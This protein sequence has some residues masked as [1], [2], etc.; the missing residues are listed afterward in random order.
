MSHHIYLPNLKS[1][2]VRDFSLYPG[3]LDFRYDFV[4]GVNLILGGNGIGKT[5]FVN[6][7]KYGLIGLY[8]KDF[9]FQRTYL[10]RKIESRVQYP[11][12]YFAN[13]MDGSYQNNENAYV[14]LS[15]QLNDTQFKVKRKLQTILLE[16]VSVRDGN[17]SRL[18][19]GDT[20]TQA[21]YE[22]LEPDERK[23]YLQYRYE[24]EV[25]KAANVY[26]FDDFIFFVNEILTFDEG[27]RTILWDES[28]NSIQ[29]RLSS[30]YFNDPDED[31]KRDHA[32]G[33]A[34]YYDSL[35][36]HNS[37][38]IRAISKI[39]KQ[40][41]ESRDTKKGVKTTLTDMHKLK[42][43][44]ARQKKK[45]T[46]IQREREALTKQQRLYHEER[47]RAA[48]NYDNLENQLHDAF[49]RSAKALWTRLNP[50]YDLYL[51]SGRRNHICP[52]C[53]Q[54]LLEN[55]LSKVLS[56]GG[57]C[58]LCHQ[59]IRPTVQ[60]EDETVELQ[61]ELQK[62]ARGRQNVELQI[63]RNEKQVEKLDREYSE[64][65]EVVFDLAQKLRALEH[66]LNVKAGEKDSFELQAM[67]SEIRKLERKKQENEEKSREAEA[68]A[69][70]ITAKMD[71]ENS[72]ITRELSGIFSAFAG[73]F[74]RV[75]ASLTYDAL[76]DQRGRRFI[77]VIDGKARL[78]EEELSE[79]QRF[80][81]DH[82]YRMSLLQFFYQKPTFFMC[83]TPDSSLDVSYERNAANVFLR[84]LSRPN[85]LIITSNVNN[86]EFLDHIITQSDKIDCINLFEIGKK[87]AIQTESEQIKQILSRIKRRINAKA[88]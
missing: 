73:D 14:S 6:L 2:H 52:M 43:Q 88:N 15:F 44:I 75:D 81:V 28:E 21:K 69:E 58:F 40:V 46:A 54:D 59:A 74:L 10:G 19:K 3:G 48:L 32:R 77:P 80:F 53:N 20:I 29:E 70:T 4:K 72:R 26:S 24:T 71:A 41:E 30:K 12:E 57:E 66:S 50:K 84:F 17:N 79:S 68:L 31:A 7:I 60:P 22:R 47:T 56:N 8:K 82:S 67:T 33:Q 64:I 5:T 34:K 45:L 16:E 61:K 38:D 11:M 13:R 37:E 35:A 86:S 18:L 51:E 39:I 27:H 85:V 42:G 1:I 62:I 83:E 9:A 87:S 36:R 25:A 23:K 65:N 49:S 63:L 76:G 55:Q 78:G